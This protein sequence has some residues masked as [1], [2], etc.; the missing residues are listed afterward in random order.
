MHEDYK[1]DSRTNRNDIALIRMVHDVKFTYFIKPI[2]LPMN[3][4]KSAV[5]PG[6]WHTVSG[7]G[8]TNF[9]MYHV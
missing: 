8:Q 4:L 7:W 5:T 1:P 3:C 9:C 6:K 2:C